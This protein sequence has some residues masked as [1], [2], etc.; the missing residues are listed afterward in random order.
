[1]VKTNK[2]LF[3]DDLIDTGRTAREVVRKIRSQAFDKNIDIEFVG[4]YLYEGREYLDSVEFE[5]R[6]ASDD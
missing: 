1:M 6:T 5:K 3:L 4:A 2:I